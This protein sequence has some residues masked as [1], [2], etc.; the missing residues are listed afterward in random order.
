MTP[1]RPLAASVLALGFAS[2]LTAPLPAFAAPA[3]C[4]RAENYAAQSG[5]ELLRVDRLE[6]HNGEDERPVTKRKNSDEPNAGSG[7]D[8]DGGGDD[9]SA[10]EKSGAADRI[11]GTD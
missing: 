7:T 8:R 2:S 1:A 3:P 10:S 9:E 6:I 11:L 4:E 5:A